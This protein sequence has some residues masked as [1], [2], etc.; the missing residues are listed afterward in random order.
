[1]SDRAII[2]AVNKMTGQYRIDQVTYVDAV[3]ND[4]DPAARSCSCTA[5]YGNAEYDLPTVKLMASTDDGLLIIP[6]IGSDVK[7]IFSQ[8][9]EPFVCQYSQIESVILD[10]NTSIQFC[11]GSLGGLVKIDGLMKF[12]KTVFADLKQISTA[13]NT[14]GAPIT[15]QTRVPDK[16]DF[17]NEKIKHGI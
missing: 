9:L 5:I 12:A 14:L 16:K 1:M 17:E 8:N 2:E 10:A 11:D 6:A 4:I 13:L 7:V 15:Q 3:V